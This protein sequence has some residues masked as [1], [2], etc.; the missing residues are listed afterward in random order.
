MNGHRKNMI[1][2]VVI[3]IVRGLTRPEFHTKG[4]NIHGEGPYRP[5]YK[6]GYNIHVEGPYPSLHLEL[7]VFLEQYVG[8]LQAVTQGR[9]IQVGVASSLEPIG[10]LK[11]NIAI[12]TCVYIH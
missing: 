1:H 4:C 7:C 8:G 6:Q 2:K 3:F 12:F 9:L 10:D 5:D 11:R